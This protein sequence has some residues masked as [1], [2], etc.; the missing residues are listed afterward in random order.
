M[1]NMEP[2]YDFYDY[3][4]GSFYDTKNLALCEIN[5]VHEEG[6]L[7]E[8]WAEDTLPDLGCFEVD[9]ENIIS[10][11]TLKQDEPI[12]KEGEGYTRMTKN[13]CT[14]MLRLSSGQ[15]LKIQTFWKAQV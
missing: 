15:K 4:F 14:I 1:G 10:Q 8:H 13:T 6:T 12:Q 3:G 5:E 2:D 9:P 7:V 11:F